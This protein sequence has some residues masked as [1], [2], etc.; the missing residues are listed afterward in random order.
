MESTESIPIGSGHLALK[1]YLMKHLDEY[2]FCEREKCIMRKTTCLQYQEQ[3]QEKSIDDY[4]RRFLR[5]RSLKAWD[6]FNCWDCEQ[7]KRI[8]KNVET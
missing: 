5:G 3:A 2:F 1:E 7:G 4:N 6:R 8:K